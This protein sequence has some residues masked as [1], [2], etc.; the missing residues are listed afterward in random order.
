MKFNEEHG[1]VPQ[2]INKKVKDLIDG[3]YGAEQASADVSGSLKPKS[4]KKKAAKTEIHTE[5]DAIDEIARLEK[6]MQQ[7][8]RD[9][10]FEEA[11]VLRDRI[12]GIKESLLFWGG[13]NNKKEQP[14]NKIYHDCVN[15]IAQ[16]WQIDKSDVPEI[17][18]QWCVFEQK[19]GQFSNVKLKI[20]KSNMDFW[21]DSPEFAS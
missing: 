14:M 6:Q 18:A 19:H 15:M 13:V 1:I 16:N 3:V 9:L 10:Q 21:S 12:R 11:A 8:A 7:A 2:Q 5:Q 17:L 20:A 4:S